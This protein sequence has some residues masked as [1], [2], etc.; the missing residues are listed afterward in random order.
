[1]SLKLH[2]CAFEQNNESQNFSSFFCDEKLLLNNI[3]KLFRQLGSLLCQILDLDF[4]DDEWAR[5]RGSGITN[6]RD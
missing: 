3:S 5:M 4:D 6:V 2:H 1:M